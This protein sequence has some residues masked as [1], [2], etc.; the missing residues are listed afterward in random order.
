MANYLIKKDKKTNQIMYMEY[1]L[2][3]YKFNPKNNNRNAF[4]EIKEVTIYN[5]KMIDNVLTTKINK[6]F[7]RIIAMSLKVINDDDATDNDAIICLGEIDLI[8][9]IIN[10]KY[11]TYIDME[12]QKAFLK[13]LL[14]IENELRMKQ[15]IIKERMELLEQEQFVGKGR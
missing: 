4:I 13:K 15:M 9:A 8:R 12:K 10:T 3:G 14:V 7:K 1:D 2:H 6:N 11:Q 5:Q